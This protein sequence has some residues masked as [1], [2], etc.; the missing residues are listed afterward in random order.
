MP[1]FVDSYRW[2]FEFDLRLNDGFELVFF[3]FLGVKPG[4]EAGNNV[5]DKFGVRDALFDDIER[6]FA[7]TEAT[8]FKIFLDGNKDILVFFLDQLLFNG[9]VEDESFV[10]KLVDSFVCFHG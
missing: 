4:N 3:D 2:I 6:D 10:G 8:C 9:E 7:G 1:V 5:F